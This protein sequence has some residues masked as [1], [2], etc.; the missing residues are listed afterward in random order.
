MASGQNITTELHEITV[1]TQ[2]NLGPIVKGNKFCQKFIAQDDGL[3][4]ISLW[5]ATYCKQI[6]LIAKTSLLDSNQSHTLREVE[7]QYPQITDNSWQYFTFDPIRES[8]G[9]VYWF[10]FEIYIKCDPI[11]LWTNKEISEICT[12]NGRPINEAICFKS[13]YARNTAYSLDSLIFKNQ[14]IGSHLSWQSEQELHHIIYS[15]IKTKNLDFLRLAHLV[16]AFGRTEAV[17]K[18]LSIGCGAGYQEAF[19]AGRF[20][21]IQVDATD[22]SLTHHTF[23]FPNLKFSELDILASLDE[24]E[25]DFV[26]SIECLEHIED[27]QLAFRNMAKKVKPGKYLYISVPFASEEEQQDKEFK[28][29][30]WKANQHYLPGF[31]FR[32]L[33]TMFQENGFQVI[34]ASNMFNCQLT[35]NL[36]A[37]IAKMNATTIESALLEIVQLF[38]IDIKARQVGSRQEGDVGVCCLGQ[39]AM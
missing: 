23:P 7:V 20:P 11:T 8:Q 33:E 22:I 38:L 37:L 18:V 9:N 3:C 39:K 6:D 4:G 16:D 27:Y 15:C 10:C 17:E 25:Y 2:S 32:D 14:Q 13:H 21:E 28:Q 1:T 12:K 19:L 26:M 31:T 5:I 29:Q 35:E 36:N 30:E 34:Q 24:A